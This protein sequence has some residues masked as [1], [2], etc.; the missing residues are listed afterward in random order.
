MKITIVTL[1]PKMV[2]PFFG[3]SIVKRAKEKKIIDIEVVDLRK[4]ATDK[5]RTVDDRPYGGGAGMVIKV[6]VVDRALSEVRK[7]LSGKTKVILTSPRGKVFRQSVAREYS[8]LDNLV[9]VAG[10]YEGFD[11]RILN[12]VDE[13]ISIGDFVLTGGEIPAVTIVDAVVRLI[14]GVLKKGE[15]VESESFCIEGEDLL[16]YPQYTRPDEYKGMKVPEILL[17][18]DHEK[19][20]NWRLEKA[21][22]TTKKNRPDLLDLKKKKS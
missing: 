19:I 4:F 18:G 17:C 8:T 15:A 14:P 5:Y 6:D 3:E 9:I 12:F 11:E 13:E 7:S 1:F 21:R 22:E 20:N 2:S 16:E 10:H